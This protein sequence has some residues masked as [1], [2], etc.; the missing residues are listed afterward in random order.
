MTKKLPL[1]LWSNTRLPDLPAGRQ[2]CLHKRTCL[3]IF[4]LFTES[5]TPVAKTLGKALNISPIKIDYLITGYFGRATGFIMGKPGIY[6][7]FNTINRQFYLQSGRKVQMYYNM[8]EKNDQDYTAMKKQLGN[9]TFQEKVKI[10]HDRQR[11]GRITDLLDDYR[12]IDIEK[13][14]QKAADLRIRIINEIDKL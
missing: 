9:F 2:A 13:M 12:D 7:P 5:T 1:L 11:L 14:P 4:F 8:K 6:N 3:P 10:R